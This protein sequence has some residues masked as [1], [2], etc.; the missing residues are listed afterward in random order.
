MDGVDTLLQI[1]SYY[2]KRDPATQ[3]EAEMVDNLF[4]CVCS[5]LMIPNNQVKKKK[6]LFILSAL[7][8]FFFV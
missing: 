2:R 5:V 8:S 1:V 3:E 7:L 6:T 4:D